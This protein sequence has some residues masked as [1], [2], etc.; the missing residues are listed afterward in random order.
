MAE[1]LDALLPLVG[2]FI[3]L[4]SFRL[5][6]IVDM[7]FLYPNLSTP[8]LDIRIQPRIK[9]GTPY[10]HLHSVE[11]IFHNKIGIQLV[12]PP[13]NHI[14]IRLC[15]FREQQEFRSRERLKTG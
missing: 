13:D 5:P 1:M 11:R 15:R 6:F 4:P 14:H 7:P 12:N 9:L 2:H 3:D 8:D 10:R